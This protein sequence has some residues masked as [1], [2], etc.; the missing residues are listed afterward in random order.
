MLLIPNWLAS[1]FIESNQMSEKPLGSPGEHATLR[2]VGD[3][4]F[5]AYPT[6][7]VQNTHALIALYMPA[8]VL[9]K[10]T[11]H[12]PTPQELLSPEKIRIVDCQW[13]R[14]DVLML[15]VPGEPFS[16]YVMWKTGTKDLVCWYINLQEPIRRTIIGFDTMD[17]MLDVVVSPDMAE[18]KWKDKDEFSEAERVG[19]YSH[20][21]ARE[22][23]ANGE[24]AVNLVT[25]ERQPFYRK[26]EKWH[27]KSEWD[28]P[29]LSPIWDR[30][31][32]ST[33]GL[34]K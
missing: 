20:E 33:T 17:N 19:F 6:I 32:L 31:D 18:W 1:F 14:T 29:K 9:G 13:D 7:V 12:R 15:I 11:D 26:W 21:K 23:W 4:V 22:I 3:K 16:T 5:W 24:K 30:M 27:A 28:I 34:H 8:G 25:L 2:G 10:D